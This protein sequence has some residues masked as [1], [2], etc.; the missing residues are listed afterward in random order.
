MGETGTPGRI[1][2]VFP[3]VR[4]GAHEPWISP[5]N[6][7]FTLGDAIFETLRVYRGTPF[8]LNDHLNR[9]K[10]SADHLHIPLPGEINREITAVLD[11]GRAAGMFEGDCTLR[12]TLSR[13]DAPGPGLSTS[14]A[15]GATMAISLQPLRAPREK[16]GGNGINVVVAASRRNERSATACHKTVSCA[17]S[18]LE[19]AR[20]QAAGADDCIF[21]DTEG[22]VSEGSASNVFVYDGDV[23]ATP[24]LAC[25]ALPG[26][27]RAVVMELAR[28]MSISVEER[29]VEKE[30]LLLAREAFLTSS[31]REL[32]ALAEIDGW[33]LGE[34]GG[35]MGWVTRELSRAYND[36]VV[37][38]SAGG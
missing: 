27:T 11:D 28:K 4:R 20:A 37:E 26:I 35:G 12:I 38:E 18:V 9:M 1:V 5:L 2:R 16:A 3:T 13:G 22:H 30:E 10:H 34:G 23:L 19:L 29:T 15:G 25:G 6:R 36:K 24:A 8:R 33:Q 32:V 21:L 17:D 14:L 7:G 31:V